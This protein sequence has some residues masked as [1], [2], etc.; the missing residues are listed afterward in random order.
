MY[1]KKYGV[2]IG[3]GSIRFRHP[4][5]VLESNVRGEAG[6]LY[7]LSCF[8]KG[9]AGGVGTELG[10]HRFAQHIVQ[11]DHHLSGRVAQ[12]WEDITVSGRKGLTW[13]IL[14]WAGADPRECGCQPESR[15]WTV[16]ESDPET[17]QGGRTSGALIF[18]PERLVF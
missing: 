14:V 10:A 8:C 7:P 1:R 4:L 16:R 11:R 6:S 18:D 3:F 5:G 17:K 13:E 2:Y 12:E 15:R 9:M